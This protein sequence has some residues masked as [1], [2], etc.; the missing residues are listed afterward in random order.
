MN[1]NQV[2]EIYEVK[3]GTLGFEVWLRSTNEYLWD[4]SEDFEHTTKEEVYQSILE[5]KLR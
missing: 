2:K 4:I 3:D 5:D 1:L